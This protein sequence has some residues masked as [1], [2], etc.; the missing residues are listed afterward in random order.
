MCTCLCLTN[1]LT[2]AVV[3]PTVTIGTLSQ[4]LSFHTCSVRARMLFFCIRTNFNL[5][6]T[7][8][9]CQPPL[10][11]VHCM[12]LFPEYENIHALHEDCLGKTAVNP[13]GDKVFTSATVA[14]QGVVGVCLEIHIFFFAELY[15]IADNFLQVF[16]KNIKPTHACLSINQSVLNLCFSSYDM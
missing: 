5:L 12:P 1:S 14:S 16:P 6:T 7:S 10:I 11:F 13:A 3:L 2:A 9:S 4:Q 15:N 8:Y